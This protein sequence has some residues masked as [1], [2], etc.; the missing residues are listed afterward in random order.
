[1][2]RD[3]KDLTDEEVLN[4]DGPQTAE[5]ARYDRIL[6]KRS[7]DAMLALTSGLSG[8][9]DTIYKMHQGLK[10]KA[11]EAFK[12]YERESRAEARRQKSVVWLTIVIAVS[13]VVYT[14]ITAASVLATR[15]AN[16]IQ[17]DALDWQKQH[18]RP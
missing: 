3:W 4:F 16:Q 5:I 1:M 7:I 18:T 13:T 2:P 9:G 12:I 10:D 8:L 15:Q 14:G 17:R 6:Q 11:D